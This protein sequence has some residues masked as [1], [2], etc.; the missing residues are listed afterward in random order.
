[1]FNS[2]VTSVVTCTGARESSSADKQVEM[3]FI[4]S[5]E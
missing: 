5:C 4:F 1:M 2:N 3:Q